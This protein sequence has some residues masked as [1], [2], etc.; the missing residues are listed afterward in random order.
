MP[1]LRALPAFEVMMGPHPVKQPLPTQQLSQIDPFLLVHHHVGTIE[2]GADRWDAGVGP[3]P[4][5]GF[6]PITFIW[7]GGVH[8]R[9]SR[10]NNAVVGAGGV[11]WMDVGMGI[12]HSERPPLELCEQGGTQ[13]IIQIWVNL[14]K[15]KKMMQPAYYPLQ[16]E[17]LPSA[18]GHPDF[19]VVSGK[20][21][22]EHPSGPIRAA[23]PVSSAHGEVTS[24]PLTFTI[25][26]GA[27]GLLYVLHGSGRLEGYGLLEEHTMYHLSAGAYTAHFTAQSKVFIIAAAPIGEKVESYGPFVMT[28]QT[29]IMEAM[30]DY[31]MGKMGYLVERDMP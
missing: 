7:Q 4:H 18:V 29:E 9:D 2:A 10:G 23:Y 11:Q 6:S 3:H 13:E 26:E 28:N 17:E 14:P 24:E 31:Q 8:H 20:L 12:I 27:N 1:V 21:G 25:D 30:R 5:R 16:K 22:P 19:K 15:S